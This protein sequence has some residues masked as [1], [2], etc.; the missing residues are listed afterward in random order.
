MCSQINVFGKVLAHA[1]KEKQLS[2]YKL[3]Q[4]SG[5]NRKTILDIEKGV[6]PKALGTRFVIG[7][8]EV[9]VKKLSLMFESK[10]KNGKSIFNK[11]IGDT[12]SILVKTK[13][14]RVQSAAVVV[15]TVNQDG[16]HEFKRIELEIIQSVIKEV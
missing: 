7:E 16:C 14:N 15:D 13:D 5:I 2:A 1:R 11:E 12:I 4:K 10:D 8:V 9:S 6:S 3:S